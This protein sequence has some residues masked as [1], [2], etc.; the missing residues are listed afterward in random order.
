MKHI[1]GYING[2]QYL[3]NPEVHKWICGWIFFIV[4][5]FFFSKPNNFPRSHYETKRLI[6][7]IGL[8]YTPIDVYEN[9][10]VL[11]CNQLVTLDNCQLCCEIHHV[12]RPYKIPMKVLNH[13]LIILKL[14]KMY[15]TPNL[16]ELMRSW[17]YANK[18]W[19]E[20][21]HNVVDSKAWAHI[22]NS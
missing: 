11:Y 2:L 12:L 18:T 13:F 1:D 21:I 14:K 7:N 10:C 15:K 4:T 22:D 6:Q 17:P 19:D 5:I 8:G 3:C 20:S 16:L 9:G